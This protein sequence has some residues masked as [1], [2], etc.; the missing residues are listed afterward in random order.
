M[1]FW[2]AW[3]HLFREM[4]EEKR[5]DAKR[6]L[7]MQ[8]QYCCHAVYQDVQKPSQN[9]WA[10]TQDTME[11]AMLREKGLNQALSDLRSPGSAHQTFTSD[12]LESRVLEEQV[13]LIK[14][15]G[16]HV[17]NLCKL[18]GPQAGLG[19]YL[20]ERLT[21]RNEADQQGFVLRTKNGL[22][23]VKEAGHHRIPA[24]EGGRRRSGPVNTVPAVDDDRQAADGVW[25]GC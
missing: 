25:E 5:E 22:S 7:K 1:W 11:A 6:L 24:V 8:N 18:T 21:L 23:H 2:R 3:D 13:K 20:L 17:T 10:Q 4:G 12:F 9:E 14:K 15:M 19:E 16:D